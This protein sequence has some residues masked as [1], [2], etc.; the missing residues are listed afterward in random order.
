MDKKPK[1]VNSTVSNNASL[2]WPTDMFGIQKLNSVMDCEC[3]C[4]EQPISAHNFFLNAI[5]SDAHNNIR[6]PSQ[7]SASAGILGDQCS[8]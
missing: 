4:F 5:S 3:C 1:L 7:N 6:N 2:E 8:F